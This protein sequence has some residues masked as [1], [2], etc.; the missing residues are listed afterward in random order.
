MNELNKEQLC[1][2]I[3]VLDDYKSSNSREERIMHEVLMWMADK[4]TDICNEE[5]AD[6]QPIWLNKEDENNYKRSV[7][8][9]LSDHNMRLEFLERV[10]TSEFGIK[11]LMKRGTKQ[12]FRLTK[13]LSQR[14]DMIRITDKEAK[15]LLAKQ[16]REGKLKQKLALTSQPIWKFLSKRI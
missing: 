3:A 4:V 2:A 7:N 14:P 6:M 1:L 8:A 12:V 9:E 13:I 16:K 5:K 10:C 11:W 15:S